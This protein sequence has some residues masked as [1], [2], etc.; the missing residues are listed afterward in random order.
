MIKYKLKKVFK[1][2]LHFL[3]IFLIHQTV[4]KGGLFACK[5]VNMQIVN[6][7]INDLIPYDKNPRKNDSAVKYVK[8]S[9]KEFGFKVPI[10]IDNNHVVIAGHTRLKAAKELKLEEVPCIIA[11]DLSE[12]Q[13][14]AFRLADNKVAEFSE[15]DMELLSGELEEILEL[16]MEEFGF[17]LKLDD[18]EVVEDEFN[19]EL[20]EEPQSKLGDIYQLGRHRLMCGDSTVVTDVERL[21]GG[22][23]L[24][25]L[26]PTHLIMLHM[27]ERQKIS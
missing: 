22:V 17:E 18:E 4:H 19:E 8:E 13:I 24:I 25:C 6:F 21:M 5:G 11:D 15:W 10:V 20:P 16:D 1:S 26:L 14:K 7:K 3:L 27:R 23:R 2:L 12:E 9:I